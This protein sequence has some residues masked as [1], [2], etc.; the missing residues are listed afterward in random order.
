MQ[1]RDPS[2][3][4]VGADTS[5]AP[6]H[7]SACSVQEGLASQPIFLASHRR[8]VPAIRNRGNS[9]A[10]AGR[11]HIAVRG[12]SRCL[13]PI[14]IGG[15]ATAAPSRPRRHD[16]RHGSHHASVA[17]PIL[18]NSPDRGQP[19]RRRE[20]GATNRDADS[21]SW[22][23]LWTGQQ[24]QLEKPSLRCRKLQSDHMAGTQRTNDHHCFRWAKAARLPDRQARL[25]RSA[26][27]IAAR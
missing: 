10:P 13:A 5:E 9:S 17:S 4:M 15:G 23:G 16:A 22:R 11:G 7:P 18:H 6:P 26:A 3:Q 20:R 25:V 19:A 2:H 1:L 21:A 14:T 24:Q 8:P 12:S 27:S